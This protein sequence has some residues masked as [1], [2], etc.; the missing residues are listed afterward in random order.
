MNYIQNNF[1]ILDC[2]LNGDEYEEPKKHNYNFCKDC[3]K[4]MLIDYQ[5]SILVCMNCGLCESYQAYVRLCNHT[6][7]PLRSRCMYKR[8]D[9]F[10][11]ILNQFFCGGKQLVPDDVMSAIRNEIHNRD[12]I[13]YNYAI[14]LTIPILKCILKRN[15]MMKYKTSIYYIFL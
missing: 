7:K 10:K 11:T 5:K 14:P 15:K 1:D 13:L 2:E 3:S 12:N 8:S 9:N 4:E 6:M